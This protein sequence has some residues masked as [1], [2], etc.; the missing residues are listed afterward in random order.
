M[1]D[2][3]LPFTHVLCWVDGSDEACRAAERAARLAKSLD[4]RLSFLALGQSIGRDDGFEAYARIEG[5]TGASSPMVGASTDACLDQAMKIAARVGVH[6]ATRLTREGNPVSTICDVAQ[7]E[8]ADLVVI[9][10]HRSGLVD[11]LLH[12]S[13]SDA[14][15][16]RCDFAVLSDG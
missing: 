10:K 6:G 11:R 13:V 3:A 1:S 16:N 14:L 5:V 7:T 15:A 2:M 4:A 9:R 12:A 8:G